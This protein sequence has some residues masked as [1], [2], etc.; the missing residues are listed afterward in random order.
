[1]FF[2][3]YRAFCFDV[4]VQISTP[5]CAFCFGGQFEG[6]LRKS[7]GR[8]AGEAMSKPVIITTSTRVGVIGPWPNKK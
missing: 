3:S 8:G 4:L 2:L 7:E 5:V 6:D 1:M